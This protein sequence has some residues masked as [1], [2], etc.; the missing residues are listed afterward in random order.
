MAQAWCM[1]AP[2]G[3]AIVAVP[4]TCAE[5]GFLHGNAH[6]AYGMERTRYIGRGFEFLGFAWPG[7]AGSVARQLQPLLLFRKP[8]DAD[9][10]R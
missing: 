4:H 3:L 9:D 7:C 2:G 1:L 5:T 6:R 10:A 8:A